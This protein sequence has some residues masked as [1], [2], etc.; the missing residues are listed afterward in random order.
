M[1][2]FAQIVKNIKKAGVYVLLFA[3]V[4]VHCA[5]G[6]KGAAIF[7]PDYLLADAELTDTLSFPTPDHVQA[8]LYARHSPLASYTES[9]H[10]D[11]L[12]TLIDGTAT[13]LNA[14]RALPA[15]E[16]SVSPVQ[17]LQSAFLP[18]YPALYGV[19]TDELAL[20]TIAELLRGPKITAAQLIW[21]AGQ[22]Y[23]ISPKFLITLLQKEQSLVTSATLTTEQ[24]DWAM[25][26]GACDSCDKTDAKRRLVYAGFSKQIAWAAQKYHEY[27]Q[28]IATK[29]ATISG[30]APGITKTT[31]DGITVTPVNSATA[32]L[33]TYNPWVGKYGGGSARWGGNSLLWKRWQEWFQ[34][35]YPD[36]S[37]LQIAGE[38]GVWY[39]SGNAVHPIASKSVLLSRFGARAE[40]RILQVSANDLTQYPIGA[41]LK[42]PNYA[43]V[44]TGQG[45]KYLLVDGMRRKFA[46]DEAFRSIGINPEE[47]ETVTL[48]DIAG[49]ASGIPITGASVYPTGMLLQHTTSGGVYFVQDGI[50][51]PIWSR[52]LLA[53]H[54]EG[55]SILPASPED[56][57]GYPD[58]MPVT[59]PDGVLV[60]STDSPVVYVISNG[61][62][63]PIDTEDTFLGL[64]Y[65]WSNV[66]VAHTRVL[67]LH[68]TGD[69]VTLQKDEIT[70][71]IT[72]NP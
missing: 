63:R 65:Q 26:A 7:N 53:L 41:A 69:V 23:G 68:P 70:L 13:L 32:A 62:K 52:D 38:P 45:D 47:L 2:L 55:K 44:A 18:D 54:F 49:Y 6:A 60:K 21:E 17:I 56:L 67:D 25:G 10:T 46:D 43:V 14:Q 28:D 58:G 36:G 12:F 8:F 37:L 24:L 22:Y 34:T 4:F 27:L 11:N 15:N 42:F 1:F 59:F 9:I 29:G 20:G 64:G 3:V 30:W 33:Y 39:L 72:S 66:I 57:S 40:R 71:A 35:S 5:P 61:L 51:H 16:R 31:V 48:E 50:K 19:T